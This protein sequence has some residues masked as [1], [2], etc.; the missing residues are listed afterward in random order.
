MDEKVYCDR[1][2]MPDFRLTDA[3][4]IK[5]AISDFRAD[6]SEIN[7]SNVLRLY[8]S[9]MKLKKGLIAGIEA[10][11]VKH[12]EAAEAQSIV[13]AEILSRWYQAFRTLPDDLFSRLTSCSSQ[14]SADH[15]TVDSL[16]AA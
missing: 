6:P 8:R 7:E 14:A 3:D 15:A 10:N 9:D 1:S 16:R 2:V 11:C 12:R 13:V 5:R 4:L